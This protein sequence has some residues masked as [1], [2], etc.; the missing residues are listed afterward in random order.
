MQFKKTKEG[1]VAVEL[2]PEENRFS[3]IQSPLPVFRLNKILVPVDFSECSM[4]ALQ[5]A[6]PFAWKLPMC[7][8]ESLLEDDYENNL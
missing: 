3:V 1:G 5:Y 6:I 2:G 4:K 8:Y 7:Q